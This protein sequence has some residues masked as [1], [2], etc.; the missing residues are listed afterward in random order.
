[1]VKLLSRRELRELYADSDLYQYDED[2]SYNR[3][4]VLSVPLR[5]CLA[6]AYEAKIGAN[7]DDPI[8]A[9]EV[10]VDMLMH[11][12]ELDDIGT[13]PNQWLAMYDELDTDGDETQYYDSRGLAIPRSVYF[14]GKAIT[15]NILRT[16][17]KW[18]P[19]AYKMR[20]NLD[21][22]SM[23]QGYLITMKVYGDNSTLESVSGWRDTAQYISN[24]DGKITRVSSNNAWTIDSSTNRFASVGE[25]QESRAYTE[26]KVCQTFNKYRTNMIPIRSIKKDRGLRWRNRKNV[27]HT[28]VIAILNS[29]NRTDV[30]EYVDIR[31]KGS[32][33]FDGVDT[34]LMA[35]LNTFSEQITYDNLLELRNEFGRFFRKFPNIFGVSTNVFYEL[36]PIPEVDHDYRFETGLLNYS[37]T[38]PIFLTSVAQYGYESSSVGYDWQDPIWYRKN[39]PFYGVE[40]ECNVKQNR[41]D[42]RDI[43]VVREQAI[44]LFHPAMYPEGYT[45]DGSHQLIYAKRDGSLNG[46]YGVEFVSQ[47]LS[48][49]YWVNHVPEVF[50]QYFKDNFL[51]R[52]LGECGIHVHI[53]WDSMTVPER[54][55]FLTILEQMQEQNS[56]LLEVI[57]GRSSNSYARWDSLVYRGAKDR[58]FQVALEK[59]QT[60]S[61]PKYNAINTTHD[62]TI[63]LRYFQGNTGRNS[64]LSIL[65]FIQ[66][67]YKFAGYITSNFTWD[68]GVDAPPES[69]QKW[70]N[71]IR[72]DVD[73][74]IL[75]YMFE[76]DDMDFMYKR[77]G[78]R[79]LRSM[80]NNTF[81]EGTMAMVRYHCMLDDRVQALTTNE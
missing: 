4:G 48:Y 61:N 66:T 43:H 41:P 75:S 17:A 28:C 59:T 49:D 57:A 73:N 72:D 8:R 63:E 80:I 81:E 40:L 16:V 25:L 56:Y 77:I 20:T 26:C 1:M 51:A 33:A 31:F 79:R 67:L 9:H 76:T 44:K 21:D 14:A 70:I 18:H 7:N 37:Y 74:V 22:I 55:V 46:T 64:I 38:F 24:N 32:I 60:G 58:A 78:E 52:N 10:V 30:G 47:P 6:I 27:C 71:D 65:Q 53:G 15:N 68:Y 13:I 2:S 23:N 39:G 42:Y 3:V 69:L 5:D 34:L 35:P 54:Y 36:R 19:Y 29:K 50:W 12:W 62:A 45:Q 11:Y